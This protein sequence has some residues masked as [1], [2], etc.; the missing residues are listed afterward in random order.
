MSPSSSSSQ[1]SVNLV[2][3]EA[4]ILL[5]PV[6]TDETNK[7]R[8]PKLSKT[9]EHAHMNSETVSMHRAAHV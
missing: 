8:Q 9:N 5:E 2:E 6:G 7:T 1:G 3:E 4:E